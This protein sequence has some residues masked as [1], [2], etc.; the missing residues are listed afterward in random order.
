V[1]LRESPLKESNYLALYAR[2]LCPGSTQTSGFASIHGAIRC[3]HSVAFSLSGK[4]VEVTSAEGDSS[5]VHDSEVSGTIA[6]LRER[7]RPFAA[8][9]FITCADA[10]AI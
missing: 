4:G 10:W 8:V 2:L 6:S 7:L 1:L 9:K 5:P 3:G